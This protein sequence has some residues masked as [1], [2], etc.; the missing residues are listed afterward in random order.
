MSL[1]R[2]RQ[3]PAP[4]VKPSYRIALRPD[5]EGELDDVVVRD[6]EMFR[7]ERMSEHDFWIA[8]YFKGT[9]EELVFN[10][11]ASKSF[12]SASIGDLPDGREFTFEP[13]SMGR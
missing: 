3:V 12:I 6:V 11:H 10:M 5:H 9:D 4:K 1:A 8:L 7:M 13:G 2:I